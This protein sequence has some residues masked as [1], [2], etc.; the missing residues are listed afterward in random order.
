MN[1]YKDEILA[2]VSKMEELLKEIRE[3]LPIPA[4]NPGWGKRVLTSLDLLWQ[5][6]KGVCQSVEAWRMIVEWA[7]NPEPI[8]KL[9]S[10]AELEEEFQ[11]YKEK[12]NG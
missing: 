12:Q 11:K 1:P 4:E 5:Q 3:K 9:P 7:K 2:I 6:L 10:L 8:E